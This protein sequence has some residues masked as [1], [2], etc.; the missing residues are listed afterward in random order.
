MSAITE[1][2]V[3]GS[4]D[5]EL[6]IGGKWVPATGGKTFAVN[7]PSTGKV[8]CEVADA[9]PEDGAAALDAAVAAFFLL[10]VIVILVASAHEW[11]VVLTGRKPAHTT[12]IPF[13]TATRAA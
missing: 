12:E 8:L 2:G 4:V 6:F 11:F 10:S 7:D 3:V 13:Q 5:K 9:S 1:T